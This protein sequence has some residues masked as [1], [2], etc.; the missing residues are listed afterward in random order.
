[1]RMGDIFVGTGRVGI[2]GHDPVRPVILDP[3]PI[4]NER[5]CPEFDSFKNDRLSGDRECSLTQVDLNP[6]ELVIE[7]S[8]IVDDVTQRDRRHG[9]MLLV[10]R[11]PE[12]IDLMDEVMQII[13]QSAAGDSGCLLPSARGCAMPTVE[14]TMHPI[15]ERRRDHRKHA[16]RFRLGESLVDLDRGT[17]K[18][19]DR[20]S[21]RYLL[22]GRVQRESMGSRCV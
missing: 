18:V 5:E 3:R 6:L 21:H 7:R 11:V 15:P 17:K 9:M 16:D 12:T 13:I 2:L 10:H 4:E 1:M 20:Y 14:R 22:R 8:K 19:I